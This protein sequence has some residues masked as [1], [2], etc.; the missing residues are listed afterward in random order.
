[1]QRCLILILAFGTMSTACGRNDESP[2]AAHRSMLATS[3]G[4]VAL[5]DGG[6]MSFSITSE[7]YKQW[8]RARRAFPRA[9]IAR[10]GQVLQ[11]R[12]PTER[13]INDAVALLERNA[14]AK[15]AIES[16]GL[17]VR[18]FVELTVALEQ[19]MLMA[20][21]GGRP[22]PPPA[23]DTYPVTMDSGYLPPPAPEV[24]PYPLPVPQA[25]VAPDTTARPDTLLVQPAPY[26]RRD[27]VPRRD[28]A[29]RRDTLRPPVDTLIV[30]R[31]ARPDTI[32]DTTR[33]SP[34]HR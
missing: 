19:Q 1:M 20:A 6:S 2:D 3:S 30:P 22:A 13:S 28:T 31:P 5:A 24:P 32:R 7:R 29:P 14:R 27:T 11:P 17:S 16:A 23:T 12:A 26:P 18:G 9:L 15:R 10:F 34:V 33:T 8:D 4:E 25:P 21:G